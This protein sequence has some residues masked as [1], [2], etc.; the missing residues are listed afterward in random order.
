M[1]WTEEN[2]YR[3]EGRRYVPFGRTVNLDYLND[4]IWYIHHRPSVKS[5]A[6]MEHLTSV[7]RI[8]GAK[9]LS[10]DVIAGME[11]IVSDVLG[12]EEM[13]KLTTNGYSATD[14]VRLAIAQIYTKYA[15][16]K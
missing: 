2:V 1:S 7:Y 6:N 11:E 5:F 9:D 10:F 12:S 15:K 3:K 14:L 13:R 4:G 16:Q 8:C